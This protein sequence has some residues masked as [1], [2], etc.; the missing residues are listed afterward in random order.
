MNYV[1]LP[2][3][4]IPPPPRRHKRTPS[5]SPTATNENE[6]QNGTVRYVVLPQSYVFDAGYA[7]A[8]RSVPTVA[9]VVA[10]VGPG[11][12]AADGVS[13]S[14]AGLA[15]WTAATNLTSFIAGNISVGAA[16]GNFSGSATIAGL[17]PSTPY[18]VYLVAED[19]AG[20]AGNGLVPS[21]ARAL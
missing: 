14:A 11:G 4:P 3:L 16:G 19:V 15:Y 1:L 12:L 21:Q 7:V 9:E 17:S 5:A 8:A 13:L 18:A 6:K 10:G 2:T 20:A